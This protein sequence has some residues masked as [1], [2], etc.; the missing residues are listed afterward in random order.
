MAIETLS[1]CLDHTNIFF[2]FYKVFSFSDKFYSLKN[3]IKVK[4][5]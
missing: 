2:V 4:I 5:K 3:N 1:N